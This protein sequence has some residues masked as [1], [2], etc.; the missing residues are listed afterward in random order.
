VLWRCWI[1]DFIAAKKHKR[2]KDFDFS[3][4]LLAFGLQPLAFDLAGDIT[5]H[6][7]GMADMASLNASQSLAHSFFRCVKAG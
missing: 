7:N 3:L 4:Q 5:R 6:F 2:R 1:I